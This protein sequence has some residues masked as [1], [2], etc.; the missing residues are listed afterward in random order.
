M[1]RLA[2][3]ASFHT[4][5]HSRIL[6]VLEAYAPGPIVFNQVCFSVK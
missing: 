3:E 1:R 2:R 6:I 4:H 5:V